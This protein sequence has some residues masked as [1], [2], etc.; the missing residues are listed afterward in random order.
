MKKVRA[1]AMESRVDDYVKYISHVV[2]FTPSD[3]FD[4]LVNIMT[5]AFAIW[6]SVVVVSVFGI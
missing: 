4:A 1:Y 5:Y 6:F 2:K 3:V